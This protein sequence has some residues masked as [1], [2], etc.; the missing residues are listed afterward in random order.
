MEDYKIQESKMFDLL[1]EKGYPTD[2]SKTSEA[3]TEWLLKRNIF[4]SVT[5]NYNSEG[6][7]FFGVVTDVIDDKFSQEYVSDDYTE[8]AMRMGLFAPKIFSDN[9]LAF[10]EAVQLALTKLP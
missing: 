8:F 6:L 9:K 3:V 4:P 7:I 2:A 1:I 5:A 10:I